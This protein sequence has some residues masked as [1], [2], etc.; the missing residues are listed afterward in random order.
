ML[1]IGEF[2]RLGSVSARMLRHYDSVGLLHPAAADPA[3]GYRR[4]LA[5]QLPELYRIVALRASGLT[6]GQIASLSARGDAETARAVLHGRA[7][8]LEREIAQATLGL[9]VVRSQLAALDQ[10]AGLADDIVV[11]TLPVLRVVAVRGPAP[12]FGPRHMTPLLRPA[13]GELR[14]A[15]ASAKIVKNG[16]PFVF[17]TGHPD[18]GDLVFHAAFPVADDVDGVAGPA[19]L[20]EL[21]AVQEAA[22]VARRGPAATAYPRAYADLRHWMEA[23]GY[24]HPGGRRNIFLKI[25]TSRPEDELREINLPLERPRSRKPDLTPRPL[26]GRTRPRRSGRS[27]GDTRRGAADR[28]RLAGPRERP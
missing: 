11:R 23:T 15:C 2:S 3:T 17:Y 1:T 27:S 7:A 9:R 4:Y 6:L 12:G 28:A 25:G 26:G 22:C 13:F 14:S 20:F 24:R 16:A 8:E 21:P 19:E 10:S 18:Q 5:T